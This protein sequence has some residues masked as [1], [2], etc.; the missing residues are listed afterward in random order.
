MNKRIRF[1]V[2]PCLVASSLVLAFFLYAQDAQKSPSVV[3]T[4]EYVLEGQEGMV[5]WTETHFIWVL[6]DKNRK[7]FQG[8]EATESEKAA[9]F[10]SAFADGGT[11]KF[12]GPSRIT[13]HRLFS[14]NPNLVGKDLTFEYEFE[15]ELCR[16]WILQPD[17]SRGS[18]G[19][20]RRVEK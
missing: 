15:G 3:G 1:Y 6:S 11:Y 5:T 2:W 20:T 4:Y 13:V 7:P 9:A 14:T 12:V 17:G 19:M 16:Y 18:M 8:T 10:T